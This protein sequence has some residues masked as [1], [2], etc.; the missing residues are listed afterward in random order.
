MKFATT[1]RYRRPFAL[2]S[3]ICAACMKWALRPVTSGDPQAMNGRAGEAAA[4]GSPSLRGPSFTSIE[5]ADLQWMLNQLEAL[6]TQR[7][8][9]QAA[10]NRY[11]AD[12][13]PRLMGALNRWAQTANIESDGSTEWFLLGKLINEVS[14]LWGARYKDATTKDL[15]L[16][17]VLI[18]ALRLCH[19][20]GKDP[21]QLIRQKMPLNVQKY[22]G[23]WEG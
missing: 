12:G 15:E 4:P 7:N 22:G 1:D 20:R 18:V 2:V 23:V 5:S 6:R 21:L 3:R 8:D 9:L 17:D 10:L 19:V 13:L 16:A 11:A 14:E